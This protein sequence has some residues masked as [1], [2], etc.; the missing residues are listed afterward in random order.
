MDS[1]DDDF[2]YYLQLYRDNFIAYG[3]EQTDD[4]EKLLEKAK[5]GLLMIQNQLKI[6]RSK[7]SSEN[8]NLRSEI[9][10]LN[11]II[12]KSEIKNG[13][14]SDETER[15]LNSDAGAVERNVNTRRIYKKRRLRTI[16]DVCLILLIIILGYINGDIFSA[17]RGRFSKKTQ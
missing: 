11:K 6:T 1:M 9:T 10:S 8:E 2:S 7:M 17:I 4:N 15:I 14:L 3:L 13:E 16:L 12:E 5:D